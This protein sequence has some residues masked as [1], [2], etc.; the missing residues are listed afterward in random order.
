V[1]WNID[2][3][4]VFLGPIELRYYGVCFAIG[5]LL[6][7]WRA[8]YNF[9]EW[10]L[11]REHAERLTLWVP[12]GMLLGAHYIHL[13]FYETEGLFDMPHAVG[14]GLDAGTCGFGHGLANTIGG[15]FGSVP[16]DDCHVVLGRFFGLGSGLASHG[17]G[18]GCV[19]AVY[20]FARRFGRGISL[21][22]HHYADAVMVTSIWVYPF[23]R[24][25]N[26]FNSEIVGRPTD[27]PFGVVFE[28]Y[29]SEPRHP[30]VLYEAAMYFAE[31]AF[32][33][34]LQKRY[35]RRVRNGVFFYG[36]LMTHFTLRF[37]AEFFKESQGVDE[38]WPYHLNMGHALSA[39]IVLGCAFMLF[40][41]KRFNMLAP[42]TAEEKAL[43]QGIED[44]W[45]ERGGPGGPAQLPPKPEGED[46]ELLAEGEAAPK[47][48]K[49]KKAKKASS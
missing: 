40:A 34:W 45:L 6:C 42:L 36:L 11:P 1:H 43:R 3:V 31:I 18:L 49:K 29:Y 4:I 48:K 13:L 39:P 20:F 44:G 27:G 38:G 35:A 9:D 15:W 10:R 12:V 21:G 7:A 33:I 16:E 32:A 24:L 2:P 30:V 17:G 14:S 46:A 25:G 41:T 19:L 22:F 28:R 8:P 47:K 5:L 26:F 37:I 23:V